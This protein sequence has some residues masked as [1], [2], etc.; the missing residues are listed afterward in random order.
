MGG[1]IFSKWRHKCTSKI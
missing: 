1:E